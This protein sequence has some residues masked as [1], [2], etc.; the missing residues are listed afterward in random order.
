MVGPAE[1]GTRACRGARNRAVLRALLRK[2][3]GPNGSALS[4]IA[5]AP[6]RLAAMIAHPSPATGAPSCCGRLG[7][8]QLLYRAESTGKVRERRDRVHVYLDV[9]GSIGELKGALYG[10]VLDCREVVHPAVH[11][12][13]TVVHDVSLPGCAM[14]SA[15][16]PAARVSSAWPRHMAEASRAARG[17]AYRWLR[18]A[19]RPHGAANAG[20][21]AVLGVALT[22]A[23]NRTDL[24]TVRPRF[25][26]ELEDGETIVLYAAEY[27]LP[28]SPGQ[29]V[30]RDRRRPGR[31]GGAAREARP[32][33][34]RGGGS[35]RI[36]F[37]YRADRVPRSRDESRSRISCASATARPA[38]A[39]GWLPAPEEVEVRTNLCLGPLLE[40]E[41]AFREVCR[42]PVDRHRL[43]DRFAGHELSATGALAGVAAG[44]AAGDAANRAAGPAARAGREARA[45]FRRRI[46][47]ARRPSPPRCS[48][49]SAATRSS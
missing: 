19:A 20:G 1:S 48:R 16:P 8:P 41:A 11:L 38:M 6:G 43:R 13:S 39:R 29:V 40:G 2:V 35:P 33:R 18:W 34:H 17:P 31:R 46:E 7:A 23:A 12:F 9:S 30:R 3:A 36:G 25:W 26:A 22:P 24:E 5:R 47:S 42:R 44:A 32:V 37:H 21:R 49:R 28:G 45:A 14:A 27:V 15:A 4:E 10:A